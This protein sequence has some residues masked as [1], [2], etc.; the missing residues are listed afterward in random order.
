M[1]RRLGAA[2]IIDPAGSI[3]SAAATVG[4]VLRAAG[5]RLRGGGRSGP[6]GRPAAEKIGGGKRYIRARCASCAR[7]RLGAWVCAYVLYV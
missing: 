2:V 6:T 3:G 5:A 4:R 1:G 7:A